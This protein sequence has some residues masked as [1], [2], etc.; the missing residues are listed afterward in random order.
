M[1]DSRSATSPITTESGIRSPASMYAWA[2]SPASDRERTA[3]RNMSPVEM[4]GTT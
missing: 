3:P 1:C 2:W 4:W